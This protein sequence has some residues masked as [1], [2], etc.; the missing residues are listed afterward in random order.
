[1]PLRSAGFIH[2]I[3]RITLCITLNRYVVG[4]KPLQNNL[5]PSVIGS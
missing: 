5:I 3:T 1:M 4:V 2:L